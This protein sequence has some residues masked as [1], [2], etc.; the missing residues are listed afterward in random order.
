MR[1]GDT[2]ALI[3]GPRISSEFNNGFSDEFQVI[4]FDLTGFGGFEIDADFRT[5]GLGDT[6]FS[7]IS[8]SGDG[9]LLSFIFESP[10]RNG[11]LNLDPHEDS[12]FPA[13]VTNAM[14]FDLNGTLTIYGRRVE[15]GSIL[16][17]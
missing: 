4:G 2:G 8:R 5:D 13:L 9:D 11:Q 14:A 12:L 7:S 15:D 17:P 10:L 3:F 1:S 6:G 16:R